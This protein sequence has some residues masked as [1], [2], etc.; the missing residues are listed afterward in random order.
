MIDYFMKVSLICKLLSII[1][2]KDNKQSIIV[3]SVKQCFE[4]LSNPEYESTVALAPLTN[5]VPDD[6][7]TSMINEVTMSTSIPDQQLTAG[8]SKMIQWLV[9]PKKTKVLHWIVT[10]FKCLLKAGKENIL[11]NDNL[12]EKLQVNLR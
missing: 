4:I 10:F 2:Q 8:I 3:L 12:K 11:E 7:I 9:W 1:W 6:V 5:Y